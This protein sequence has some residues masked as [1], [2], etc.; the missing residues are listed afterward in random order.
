MMRNHSNIHL[1]PNEIHYRIG[2]NE[3]LCQAIRFYGAKVISGDVNKLS[4]KMCK[5]LRKRDNLDKIKMIEGVDFGKNNLLFEDTNIIV[6][7]NQF[8]QPLINES[9]TQFHYEMEVQII[10]NNNTI[11]ENKELA[12]RFFKKSMEVYTEDLLDQ[13]KEIPYCIAICNSNPY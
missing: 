8:N 11:E 10:N 6:Q 7:L 5:R 13:K 9:G 2:A 3:Q 12:K 1:K 4:I